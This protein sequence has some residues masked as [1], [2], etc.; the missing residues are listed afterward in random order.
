MTA[1]HNVDRTDIS[2]VFVALLSYA[3]SMVPVCVII[4]LLFKTTKNA[5]HSTNIF[6]LQ[7]E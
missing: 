2:I 3:V 7:V 1:S 4:S 5:A 6:A